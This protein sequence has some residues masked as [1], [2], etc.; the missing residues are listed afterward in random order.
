MRIAVR[1]LAGY[2]S[3]LPEDHD[4]QGGFPYEVEEGATV[5]EVLQR[6][7][8]PP[9]DRCTFFVNGRHGRRDQTLREGDVLTLF[10]AVGGG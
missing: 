2:R 9:A 6:L 8:I 7:P 5:R 4:G 1:L 10:P 3:Y